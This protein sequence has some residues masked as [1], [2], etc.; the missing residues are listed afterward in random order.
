METK[1][2]L[3]L[4]IIISCLAIVGIT[5]S[6]A[7]FTASLTKKNENNTQIEA[8]SIGSVI[9]NG[10]LIFNET[11]VYPGMQNVQT[12]TIEKG[13]QEGTGTY[14]IDLASTLPE[15]FG[16]DIEITLYKT[17]TPETDNIERKEGS[18]T[19][20]AE[21]FIKEDEIIINGSPKVAYGPET[22]TNSSEI[23]LEQVDFNTS[24][25]AKTTYYL[26]YNYKNNGNQNTQQGNTFSGKVTVKLIAQT[27]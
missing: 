9:Y 21:G 25:L 15:V 10:E 6:F 26:V 11:N 24:T 8:A 20:T 7:Y 14:E 13:S 2:W 18:L 22:L 3:N 4:G 27:T 23:I 1:H 16:S 5:I 17:T 19:Q 12:F